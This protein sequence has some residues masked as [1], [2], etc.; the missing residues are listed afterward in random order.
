MLTL[1]F[2]NITKEELAAKQENWAGRKAQEELPGVDVVDRPCKIYL[3]GELAV[4]DAIL[5]GKQIGRAHV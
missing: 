4:Y 2:D 5:T 1:K 3:N